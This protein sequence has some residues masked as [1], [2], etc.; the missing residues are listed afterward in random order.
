MK[1]L[2]S[3]YA[4]GRVRVDGVRMTGTK[5][6]VVDYTELTPDGDALSTG[7]AMCFDVDAVE[8]DDDDCLAGESRLSASGEFI[9]QSR[10]LDRTG[11]GRSK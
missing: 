4:I 8:L 11:L 10:K 6:A 7:T 1:T 5:S 2:R 9:V 3:R